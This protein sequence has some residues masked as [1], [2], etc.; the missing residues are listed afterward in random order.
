MPPGTLVNVSENELLAHEKS[1]TLEP[2]ELITGIVPEALFE[3][4]NNSTSLA[5]EV[6]VG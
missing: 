4:V 5:L 2:W 1:T 3:F 6:F